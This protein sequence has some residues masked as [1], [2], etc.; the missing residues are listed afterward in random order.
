MKLHLYV[1]PAAGDGNPEGMKKA[2]ES[3]NSVPLQTTKIHPQQ[4]Y[5][6]GAHYAPWFGYIYDN[7]YL[8]EALKETLPVLLAHEEINFF[9]FYKRMKLFNGDWDFSKSPR[10][11]RSHVELAKELLVPKD[12]WQKNKYILDGW[13]EQ[14]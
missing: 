4:L 2:A 14:Q 8:S 3:F 7:E 10:I 5:L 6:A 1:I 11:F 9:V 12:P 13:V